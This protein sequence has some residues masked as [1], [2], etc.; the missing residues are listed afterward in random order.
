[1]AISILFLPVEQIAKLASAFMIVAFMFICGTVVVLRESAAT[2][3]R[4]T[5]RAPL[6]PLLQI[7]G[8]LAGLT[9]LWAMGLT[10]IAAFAGICLIGGLSYVVYGRHQ[11]SRLGVVG[12]MG[13][14]TDLVGGS[15]EEG[16]ADEAP[17][18]LDDDLPKEAAVVVPL[19]GS[20]RS[21]ETLV[22]MGA[23]LAHH[24]KLEVLHVTEVPEQMYLADVLDEDH[25]SIALSR[26]IHVM[27]EE[28]DVNLE[29]DT[30][31]SH[32]VVK[33]IH[34]VADQL[35]CEWVVMESARRRTKGITFQNQL[36]WLQD[37][38]PCNLAVFKDAGVRYIRKI[39]VFAE[40]GPHLS[41]IHI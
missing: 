30:V 38:L 14:R 13:K 40:P 26:R 17:H 8:I 18:D 33:T 41:L 2:W 19:F 24:R 4:P 20:E 29:Y 3:Y 15:K 35:H 32:D 10:S 12:R 9:L 5:F 23:A 34:K 27:A 11:T 1:M 36:G 37:H 31:V 28:E 6:Y 39:L 25:L 22:E 7:I 21:P 16:D